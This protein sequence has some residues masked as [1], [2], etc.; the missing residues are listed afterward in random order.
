MYLA[1]HV[2]RALIIRLLALSI[3]LTLIGAYSNVLT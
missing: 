1:G 3:D 2:Q